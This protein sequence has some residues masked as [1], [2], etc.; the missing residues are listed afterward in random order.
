[1][2]LRIVRKHAIYV[3]SKLEG[4]R[5]NKVKMNCSEFPMEQ[6]PFHNVRDAK[7][8]M[9]ETEKLIERRKKRMLRHLM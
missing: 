9:E 7:K 5:K 8:Y 2:A 4:G 3:I 1:M 6:W